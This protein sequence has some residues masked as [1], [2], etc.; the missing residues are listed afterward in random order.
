MAEWSAEL[1][2]WRDLLV[3]D[4]RPGRPADVISFEMIDRVERHVLNNRLTI[5][6]SMLPNLL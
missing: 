4:P 1:K 5:A 2:S 6:E 3:D